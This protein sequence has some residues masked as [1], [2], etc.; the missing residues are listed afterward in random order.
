M[1]MWHGMD[2]QGDV[3]LVAFNAVEVICSENDKEVNLQ[4]SAITI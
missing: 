3:D 4:V 2:G 1:R